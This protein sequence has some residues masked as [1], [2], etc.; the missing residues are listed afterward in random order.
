[1]SSKFAEAHIGEPQETF[2]DHSL[3]HNVAEKDANTADAHDMHRMGKTQ[4]TRRNFRS[5]TIL[6]FCTTFCIEW[7]TPI[8]PFMRSPNFTGT[9]APFV[10]DYAAR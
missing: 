4:E 6:G 8:Y 5:I 7:L 3:D 1:M 2:N 9:I 10:A